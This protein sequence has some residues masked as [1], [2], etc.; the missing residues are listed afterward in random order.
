MGRVVRHGRLQQLDDGGGRGGI[1]RARVGDAPSSLTNP[2]CGFRHSGRSG[3]VIAASARRSPS[4]AASAS[5]PSTS[6]PSASRSGFGARSSSPAR[7]ARSSSTVARSAIRAF[8]DSPSAFARASRGARASLSRCLASSSTPRPSRLCNAA[9]VD[10]DVLSLARAFARLL[11]AQGVI[12]M[13]GAVPPAVESQVKGAVLK[14]VQLRN[15]WLGIHNCPRAERRE[16]ITER[17]DLGVVVHPLVG[18]QRNFLESLLCDAA[19]VLPGGSGAISEAVSM[20]CLR[21]PVL[22]GGTSRQWEEQRCRSLHDL[23]LT[24]RTGASEAARL[25]ERS[26]GPLGL[27][28]PLA[29]R[30]AADV[31]PQRLQSLPSNCS[32]AST[33]SD[34]F[35]SWIDTIPQ[36][37]HYPAIAGHDLVRTDYN[38]W[39]TTL[40]ARRR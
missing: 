14:E 37:G 6:S 5:S 11:M 28:G 34:L 23:F 32:I 27:S 26:M 35:T 16:P 21:K 9:Y 39:L 20:L 13:T 18:E 10:R 31:V 38:N 24:G 30:I 19:I 2:L 17:Q 33:N 7:R 8:R 15:P 4:A 29:T 1:G 36:A 22:L 40:N 3:T 25:V 12:V